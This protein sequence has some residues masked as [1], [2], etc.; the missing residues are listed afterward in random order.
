MTETAC[1]S[2]EIRRE[3]ETTAHGKADQPVAAL[4]L[5]RRLAIQTALSVL[6]AVATPSRLR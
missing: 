1:L 4:F 3:S 2:P 6:L 5:C